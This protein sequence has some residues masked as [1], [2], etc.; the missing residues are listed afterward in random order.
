MPRPELPLSRPVTLDTIDHGPVTVDCPAWCIGHHWQQD[1]GRD[2]ITH[3]SVRVKTGTV[4]ESRGWLPMLTAWVSWAPFREIVPVISLALDA[5]GDLAAEDG[6]H[7]AEGL[8]LAASR[9]EQLA[10]EAISLRGAVE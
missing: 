10:T 7:V 1:I 4:T 2:D 9:I 8:R 6:R 5:E 3:R